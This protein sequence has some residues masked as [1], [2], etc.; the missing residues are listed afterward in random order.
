MV[1]PLRRPVQLQFTANA[2]NLD[3]DVEDVKSEPGP[4]PFFGV[5][6]TLQLTSSIC[7]RRGH[8]YFGDWQ[9]TPERRP[10]TLTCAP[11]AG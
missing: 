8:R 11:R 4:H 3:A 2:E 9:G 10:R 1:G 6:Q 5:A 7:G